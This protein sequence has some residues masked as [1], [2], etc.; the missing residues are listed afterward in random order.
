M[1][2]SRWKSIILLR[3]G[4]SVAIFHFV[5]H[6]WFPVVRFSSGILIALWLCGVSPSSLFVFRLKDPR[7][8]NRSIPKCDISIWISRRERFTRSLVSSHRFLR[9]E[10]KSLLKYYHFKVDVAYRSIIYIK[11]TPTFMH[12]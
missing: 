4:A 9:M 3:D 7:N 1:R 10:K 2:K 8:V 6:I 12:Y 5:M 11:L